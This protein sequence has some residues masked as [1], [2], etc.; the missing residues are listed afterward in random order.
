MTK[1]GDRIADRDWSKEPKEEQPDRT[2]VKDH[3]IEV[4][5]TTDP[6][7]TRGY[8]RKKYKIILRYDEGPY[9]LYCIEYKWKGNYWRDVTDWDFQDIPTPVRQQVAMVLPVNRPGELDTENRVIPEGGESRFE[10]HHK[11][12]IESLDSGEMWAQSFFGDAVDS[13]ESASEALENRDLDNTEVEAMIDR[14]RD[15]GEGFEEP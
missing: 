4:I 2:K 3:T 7:E 8:G 1:Y 6:D 10:K 12:R 15:I 13:L 5:Y 11:K 9:V 14:I